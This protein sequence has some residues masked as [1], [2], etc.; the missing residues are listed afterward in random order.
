ML[1][2][3]SHQVSIELQKSK[4]IYLPGE[5]VV[6]NIK[7][8]LYEKEKI[9]ELRC[10]INGEARVH[11]TERVFQGR[12]KVTRHFEGRENYIKTTIVLYRKEDDQSFLE[13]GD[14]SYPFKII[15]PSSD[16]PTSFLNELGKIYYSV[17]VSMKIDWY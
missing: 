8:I 6:G 10:T 9:T 3:K 15:L 7:L 16:L 14:Y 13:I 2:S 11:F 12:G 17:I 4:P 5:P 1:N